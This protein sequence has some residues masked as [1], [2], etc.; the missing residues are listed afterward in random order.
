MRARAIAPSPRA[1]VFEDGGGPPA[2]ASPTPKVARFL[3]PAGCGRTVV[4]GVAGAA[5]LVRCFGRCGTTP[6]PQVPVRASGRLAHQQAAGSVPVT[7][8]ASTGGLSCS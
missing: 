8:R 7:A 4:D 3:L 5:V 1:Q 6:A 2:P